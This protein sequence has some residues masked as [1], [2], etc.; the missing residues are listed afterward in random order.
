[1]QQCEAQLYYVYAT[2]HVLC[3]SFGFRPCPKLQATEVPVGPTHL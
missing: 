3:G 1:M 2:T